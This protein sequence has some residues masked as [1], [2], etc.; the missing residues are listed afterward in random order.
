VDVGCAADW[1]DFA[2]CK[3][4]HPRNIAD[5]GLEGVAVVAV[6]L[7]KVVPAAQA[8]KQQCAARR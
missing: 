3:K 5:F 2:R 7:I 1:A 8:R 6:L 4:I